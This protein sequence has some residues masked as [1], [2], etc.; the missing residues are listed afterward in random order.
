MTFSAD[1]DQESQSVHVW[2]HV[3]MLVMSESMNKKRLT[4]FVNELPH[5]MRVGVYALPTTPRA[6]HFT[7]RDRR[8]VIEYYKN[9]LSQLR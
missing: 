9:I 3:G 8:D 7:I 4:E 5:T 6:G 1:I 2:W